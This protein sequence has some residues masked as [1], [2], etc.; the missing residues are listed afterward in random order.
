MIQKTVLLIFVITL[1]S[2]VNEKP[3]DVKTKVIAAPVKIQTVAIGKPAP[4]FTNYENYDGTT[5]SLKDLKGKYVYIDVWATW[6]G[7]CRGE[8]PYLQKL[9]EHF[10]GK[11]IVF[12]SISIDKQSAH[13]KWKKMIADKKMGGIQLFAGADKSFTAA[14]RVNS[15]PRFIL[16]DP[17]G[18]VVASRTTR[19]SQPQTKELLEKLLN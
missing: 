12:V 7:P 17:N 19:P 3:K 11:N 6:C 4:Q 15:I 18:N 10:K 13:E 16:I 8:I 1:F 5:T 9:E 14:Y 2:C